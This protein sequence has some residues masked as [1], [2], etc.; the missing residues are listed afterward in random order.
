M[1][2]KESNCHRR[3]R[4][5]R[6]NGAEEIDLFWFIHTKHIDILCVCVYVYTCVCYTTATWSSHRSVTLVPCRLAFALA[7]FFD[8]CP[9]PCKVFLASPPLRYP[10]LSL[11]LSHSSHL[12]LIHILLSHLTRLINGNLPLSMAANWNGVGDPSQIGIVAF[13][14]VFLRPSERIKID[15][16]L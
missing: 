13:F 2:R 1:W 15:M 14:F 11:F 7:F 16:Y 12:A 4:G 6:V 10:S 8:V 5:A 3:V 9:R